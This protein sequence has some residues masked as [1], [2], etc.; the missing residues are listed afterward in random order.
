VGEVGVLLAKQHADDPVR[1]SANLA[2]ASVAQVAGCGTH[3]VASLLA[4]AICRGA[5]AVGS[6]ANSGRNLRVH[7]P[8]P[9]SSPYLRTAQ[10]CTLQKPISDRE[11]DEAA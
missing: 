2:I 6:S 11:L 1:C 4:I 10:S 7:Q 9:T 8:M 3:R 5:G